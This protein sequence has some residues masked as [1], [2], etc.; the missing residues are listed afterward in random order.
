[1]FASKPVGVLALQGDFAEHLSV[2]ERLG[3]AVIEVRKGSELDSV[4]GLIIPGGE[5]TTILKLLDRFTLTDSLKRRIAEGMPVF[6]TCAGAIVLARETSDGE[7]PLGVLDIEVKRNAYGRQ[8]DS[9]EAP[10][11]VDGIG[12][13][14]GVF[15]RAPV[16]TEV[17]GDVEV[18]AT[19]DGV[20]V[21]VRQGAILASSFHPEMT[22]ESY[23]HTYFV[24]MIEESH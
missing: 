17:G 7:P 21:L 13:I 1:L 3:I 23:L 5:S 2:L 8:V 19:L 24:E 18:L 15:I 22:D 6:G 12:V 4:S 14:E 11:V 9:F 20:P 16:I 10:V